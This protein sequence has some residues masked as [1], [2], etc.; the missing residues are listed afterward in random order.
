MR[1][2]H[3]W[4][5]SGF[6]VVGLVVLASP[7]PLSAINTCQNICN[8]EV[9]C[10]T[11]CLWGA[12]TGP[13]HEFVVYAENC[14]EYDLCTTSS[15]CTSNP[16]GCP[17]QSCTTTLN[18]TSGN[19]TLNGGSARECINGLG[20]NDTIDGNAG[21]DIITCGA[22]TDTAYGDSGNDCLYGEADGD[23]LDGESG[24]DLADGGTGTDTCYAES[25]ANCP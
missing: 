5:L 16:P 23:Y 15:G 4:V 17:A 20:G 24:T 1:A 22:G 18:G 21:D 2:N 13:E 19:D 3:L 14:G 7:A 11:E 6:L 12:F 25:T 10:A 9:S 8:C